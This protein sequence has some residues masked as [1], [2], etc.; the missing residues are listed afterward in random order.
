MGWNGRQALGANTNLRHTTALPPLS[1]L[2]S[3][4]MLSS[5]ATH[6]SRAELKKSPGD[7]PRHLE[8]ATSTTKD[9]IAFSAS[10][11][12]HKEQNELLARL[13]KLQ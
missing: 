11:F 2:S 8:V 3:T 6:P 13:A 7:F 10:R 4:N 9:F 1:P 5:L 12:K